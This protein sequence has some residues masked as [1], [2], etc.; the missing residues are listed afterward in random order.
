MRVKMALTRESE[1]IKR[2]SLNSEATGLIMSH[3]NQNHWPHVNIVVCVHLVCYSHPFS[4]TPCPLHTMPQGKKRVTSAR[5]AARK[6][7]K[8]YP[9]RRAVK[10]LKKGS[11]CH[12]TTLAQCCV[13]THNS[14][15][16][17][18]NNPAS[19]TKTRTKVSQRSH[20]Y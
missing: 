12:T 15:S 10:T 3:K 16:D 1:P 13:Y 17:D 8:P 4:P 9:K 5:A 7:S 20:C 2:Y 11:M 18:L 19:R 6:A 14:H